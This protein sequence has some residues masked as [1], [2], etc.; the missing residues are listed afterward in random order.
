MN[1]RGFLSSI[2]K[3]A[4]AF[5]ILPAATTYAWNWIRT[6]DLYLPNPDWVNADYDMFFCSAMAKALAD[7][8][9]YLTFISAG[10]FPEGAGE[11]TRLVSK[12]HSVTG[13]NPV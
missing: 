8:S 3:A 6:E 5:T 7:H 4:A 2:L 1:R 13:R 11:V 9:P 10:K 12:L